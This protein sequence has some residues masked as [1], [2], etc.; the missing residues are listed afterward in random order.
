MFEPDDARAFQKQGE[1]KAGIGSE[2]QRRS[3]DPALDAVDLRQR[4][5]H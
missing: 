2:A 3:Y 4:P 1:P 5:G